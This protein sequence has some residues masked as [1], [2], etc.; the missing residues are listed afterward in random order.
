MLLCDIGNSRYH[1][2]EDSRVKDI[3]VDASLDAFRGKKCYAVSV[4]DDALQR[5]KKVCDVVLL[6]P[7]E[8]LDTAYQGLG[9]DRAAACL[10]VD[11]GIVID[12]GSAITVDVMQS[13]LHLGGFI[14]P[15]LQSLTAAYAS[16]STKLA[17]TPA[18][19]AELGVLPQSTKEA[20]GYGIVIPIV[21]TIKEVSRGKRLYFT[22]GDGAFLARYFD[23]A[24]VDRI[25][26]FKGM[27][28]LIGFLEK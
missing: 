2:F 3:S 16:I 18:M 12:A 21:L 17:T 23:L 8:H 24:I 7:L 6:N 13:S 4:N 15:G 19:S 28:K 20:L 10:A 26:I 14:M 1:F 22:G 25:L 27:Q 9:A 5:L 11:D